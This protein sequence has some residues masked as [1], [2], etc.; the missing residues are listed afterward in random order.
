MS[1]IVKR[2]IEA[3]VSQM[4]ADIH[5]FESTSRVCDTT[6]AKQGDKEGRRRMQ[7]TMG[8]QIPLE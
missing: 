6:W 1:S 8:Y 2:N 4:V 7:N 3:D 5:R